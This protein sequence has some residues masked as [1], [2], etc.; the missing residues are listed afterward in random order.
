MHDSVI[1]IVTGRL[2]EAYKIDLGS[3]HFATLGFLAFENATKRN[4]PNLKNGTLVYAHVNLAERDMEPEIVCMSPTTNKSDGYGELS[5]GYMQKISLHLSRKL[6]EGT[7][8]GLQELGK[9]FPFEM[10]V[11][12]NGRVWVKSDTVQNTIVVMQCLQQMDGHVWTD[13]ELKKMIAGACSTIDS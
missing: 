12:Y 8:A 7:N 13:A 4:K 10:A 2:G 5:G 6:L 3:A 1:G 11:G 9:R